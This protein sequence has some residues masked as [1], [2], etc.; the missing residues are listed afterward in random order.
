M[1]KFPLSFRTQKS[2]DEFK[3]EHKEYKMIKRSN[4]PLS[5]ETANAPANQSD[6]DRMW[7]F[8]HRKFLEIHKDA[9]NFV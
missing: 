7:D 8:F 6:F 5:F 9:A 1:H 3:N 2:L 4:Q